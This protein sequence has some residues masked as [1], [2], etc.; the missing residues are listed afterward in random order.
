MPVL[1]RIRPIL[2]AGDI[3]TSA[4]FRMAP[5]ARES[6]M[7]RLGLDSSWR[8]LYPPAVEFLATGLGL[9]GRPVGHLGDGG[10]A[11]AEAGRPR[12]DVLFGRG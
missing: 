10:P 9:A 6:S 1:A 11:D 2:R 3:I 8:G 7:R 4:P 12:S 5:N